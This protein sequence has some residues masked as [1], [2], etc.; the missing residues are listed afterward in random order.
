MA[1]TTAKATISIDVEELEKLKELNREIGK[2][3][4][5]NIDIKVSVNVN[6]GADVNG[7]IKA[8]EDE[9]K[10]EINKS[11]CEFKET[12]ERMNKVREKMGNWEPKLIRKR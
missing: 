5:T 2:L 10:K 4:S 11:E 3:S 12:L 8:I 1:S 9:L 7:V 6:T